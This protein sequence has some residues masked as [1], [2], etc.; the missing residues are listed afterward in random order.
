MDKDITSLMLYLDEFVQLKVPY[1]WWKSGMDFKSDDMFYTADGVPPTALEII[2]SDKSVLCAGLINL[3]RR[4]MGLK[5]DQIELQDHTIIKGTTWSWFRILDKKEPIDTTKIYPIGTLLMRDYTNEYDQG[6]LAIIA[7]NP[8]T[9]PTT[10]IESIDTQQIIH[11]IPFYPI[12][13]PF[14]NVGNVCYTEFKLS[15]YYLDGR[16]FYT[17]ICLPEYWLK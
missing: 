11:S 12:D 7:T 4:F 10:K 17:H 8:L 13:S 6:H 14:L 5:I 16:T 1:R 3:A 9:N 15:H 2:Q